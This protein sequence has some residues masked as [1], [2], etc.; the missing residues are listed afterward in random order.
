MQK[1]L[2]IGMFIF[3]SVLAFGQKQ[4]NFKSNLTAVSYVDQVVPEA[5]LQSSSHEENPRSKAP[6]QTDNSKSIILR[7]MGGSANGFSILGNRQYLWTDQN[8]NAVCFVHRM[9]AA[10]GSGNVA[11]DYSTDRGESFTNNTQVYDPWQ[12]D[13]FNARYPQGAIYNP[14]GNTDPA[15]AFVGYFTPTLDGS[16]G[17][18]NWG[19]YAFGSHN[20]GGSQGPTVHSTTS[21]EGFIQDVPDSYSITSQGLAIA[22]DVEED[23]FIYTDNMIITRGFFNASNDFEMEREHVEMPGGGASPTSGNLARVPNVKVAFSDDGSVGYIAYLSNND[24]NDDNSEGCYHPILYRTIDDGENW[25]G[26]FN[27]QLGGDDGIPAILNFLTDDIIAE[28]FEAP[29]PDR[30]E[31]PFTTA[32]E[33]DLT[34]DNSGNPHLIFNFGVGNQEFSFFSS[35]GGN[36]GCKGCV[37]MAHVF[38]VD[39]GETWMGDTLCTVKT[40]RGEFPYTGGDPIAVDNR[41]YVSS[42]MDGSKLFFSWIDTDIE[43]VGSNSNP[44]IYCIGYDVLN[45]SYSELKNVTFL[46][47]AMWQAFMACGSKYVFDNNNGSYTIPFAYQEISPG[48]LLDPV[49]YYYIDN[50]IITDEELSVVTGINPRHETQ[51]TISGAFPNPCFGATTV[52]INLQ[53]TSTVSAYI[54]NMTGQMVWKGHSSQLKKGNHK[55][56]VDLSSFGKG[57]YIY[58]VLING[59]AFPVKILVQ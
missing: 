46:T 56:T 21:S 33:L 57:A 16:S 37:A 51:N 41:P 3:V 11:Y 2:L 25:D 29:V 30:D 23:N 28:M 54:S 42:T 12:N 43:E 45:N 22:V 8:I 35:Y 48:E 27:V 59:E 55:L 18:G 34:V 49:Q 47:N 10:P 38:S 58:T 40:F 7:E 32:F 9:P 50:F 17:S 53:K 13:G 6:L 24:E 1:T 52:S 4:M 44:D 15:N 39:G 26:P 19:G 31:I 20:F 14:A 5:V 36:T